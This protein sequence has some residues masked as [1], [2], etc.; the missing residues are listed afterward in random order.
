[1]NNKEVRKTLE[2]MKKM[3]EKGERFESVNIDS[4]FFMLKE[5]ISVEVVYYESSDTYF[6]NFLINNKIFSST[7]GDA[8]KDLSYT[9]AEV[10]R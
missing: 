5:G 4:T 3:I 1:M 7:L 6:I 10:N 9:F 2:T 8:I